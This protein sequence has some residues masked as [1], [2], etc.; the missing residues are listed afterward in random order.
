[1]STEASRKHV[2]NFYQAMGARKSG[3]DVDLGAFFTEDAE[4][5]LPR[6]SPMHGTLK[7]RAAVV[8]L[9]GDSVDEYYQPDTMKFD[10]HAEI[11]DGD[12]VVM[13]FT[14]SAVTANGHDYENDYCMMF[15]LE[16]GLIAQV[17]EFFDTAYLFSMIKPG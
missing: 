4:W 2:R 3:V 7:G 8:N 10:Y 17:R 6:S 11:A 14:L 1:M 16:D 13:Q 5:Q 9:F 15:R 12:F